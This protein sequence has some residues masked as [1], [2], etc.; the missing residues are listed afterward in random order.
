MDRSSLLPEEEVKKA[1]RCGASSNGNLVAVFMVLIAAIGPL[2]FGY[3]LGFTS[4]TTLPMEAGKGAWLYD[5]IFG[6]PELASDGTI[7]S[8]DASLFGSLVNVGCMIGALLAGPLTDCMGRKL[9]IAVAAVPWVGAWAAIGLVPAFGGVLAGRVLSGIATGIISMTVP[10][11]ISETA[12]ASMR[13][14]LGAVN[15]LAVT[16]GIFT[17]YLLGDLLQ[18][19]QQ[20]VFACNVTLDATPPS[21][22]C[23]KSMTCGA[24]GQCETHLAPW[25]LLAFIG[26]G[27]A[28]VLLLCALLVLPETPAFLVRK[29]RARAARKVLGRLRSSDQEADE[30]FEALMRMQPAAAPTNEAETTTQEMGGV[31]AATADEAVVVGPANPRGGLCALCSRQARW[32]LTIGCLLMVIQQFSGINAVIFFSSDI[33]RAAGIDDPNL[34][35]VIVM[36]VQVMMTF[37]SVLLMD[38][39]GRRVLLLVSL[40]GMTLAAAAM[41]AFHANHEQP[42]WLALASLI[43]Y[44][45]AFSLGLGAIPWLIM[46]EIFPND[47]RALA[48]SVATL[49]N[50][51]LSFIITE[52]FDTIRVAL[53]PAVTFFLFAGICLSGGVFVAICVPETKGKTLEEVQAL[54]R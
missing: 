32:P 25:R 5:S 36:A 38:R 31:V 6:T 28:G 15:Q 46:G 4:P 52:T 22:Q 16:T 45:V 53:G 41:G 40:G 30:E 8:A 12:P 19:P 27:L 43:G 39:A 14:A 2:T 13:G 9:A 34:G 49:L 35:G 17:V 23:P 1:G 29:G 33:L 54:F 44:I 42:S 10:L 21:S 37:V 7:S 51:T 47:V 11:Y 18:T 3:T 26:A 50:W 48:S 20:T 24:S